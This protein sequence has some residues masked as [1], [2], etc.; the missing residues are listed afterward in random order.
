MKRIPDDDRALFAKALG[1]AFEKKYDNARTD[2][3]E[4]CLPLERNAVRVS[5]AVQ[6]F[7]RKP[8]SVAAAVVVAVLL[9]CG[10]NS[11][12]HRE[13]MAGFVLRSTSDGI[14]IT[15]A[16]N[17]DYEEHGFER[18]DLGYIPDGYSPVKEEKREGVSNTWVNEQ[19]QIIRF[20]QSDA[21]MAS[22]VD[23]RG[24]EKYAIEHNGLQILYMEL[25]PNFVL[26]QY[27]QGR[28]KFSIVTEQ[29]FEQDEIMRM[30]DS[31]HLIDAT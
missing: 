28:Y 30:I 10:C 31:V 22:S 21:W 4:G 19:K 23:D 5:R 3:A 7:R 9:V 16:N 2:N 27:V 24:C 12:S 15:Y 26:Y 17:K 1:E 18:Y 25:N 13:K 29:R 6:L 11:D 20:T 8:L 14:L